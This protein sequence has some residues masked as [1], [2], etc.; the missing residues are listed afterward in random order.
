MGAGD[1]GPAKALSPAHI[2]GKGTDASQCQ[3]GADLPA[4]R[5]GGLK[6]SRLI[7]NAT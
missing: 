5:L 2:D 1:G 3:R 4:K 6:N 7:L